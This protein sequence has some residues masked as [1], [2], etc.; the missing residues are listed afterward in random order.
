MVDDPQQTSTASPGGEFHVSELELIAPWP[1]ERA[2]M[3]RGVSTVLRLWRIR[4]ILKS[5]SDDTSAG[6]SARRIR[7]VTASN[8]RESRLITRDDRG[9]AVPVVLG[10]PLASCAR[11]PAGAAI[12]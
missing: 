5:P 12:A 7:R 8:C 6:R 1:V 2:N 11:N 4:R 9:Q 3:A 10:Q